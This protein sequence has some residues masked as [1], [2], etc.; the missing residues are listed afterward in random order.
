[1]RNYLFC[2]FVSDMFIMDFLCKDNYLI[3]YEE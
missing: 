1:M 2:I 3:S